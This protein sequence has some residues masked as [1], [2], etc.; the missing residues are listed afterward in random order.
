M[1]F[2]SAIEEVLSEMAQEVYDT[3]VEE[4]KNKL[5][6]LQK[7]INY[8]RQF[9]R[10]MGIVKDFTDKDILGLIRDARH[11][12]VTGPVKEPISAREQAKYSARASNIFKGL[13]E[14]VNKLPG[15][16]SRLADDFKNSMSNVPDKIRSAAL[17]FLTMPQIEEIYGTELPSLKKLTI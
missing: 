16:D 1:L 8:I 6:A 3:R 17:G 12:V 7:F 10:R 5:S 2:R 4:N 11:A 13:N 9:F 15:M 14:Q